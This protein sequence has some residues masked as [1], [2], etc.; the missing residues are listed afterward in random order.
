MRSLTVE[1]VIVEGLQRSLAIA[2]LVVKKIVERSF[3]IEEVI[4]EGFNFLWL[5]G[6]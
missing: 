4:I 5:R 2:E 3:T 6:R 1:E